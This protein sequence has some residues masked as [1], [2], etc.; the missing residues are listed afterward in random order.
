VARRI[1]SGLATL[2]LMLPLIPVV[3]EAAD[4]AHQ[5]ASDARTADL[6]IAVDQAWTDTGIS[7][8]QGDVLTVTADGEFVASC[9]DE[10]GQGTDVPCGP[11]GRFDVP[12]SLADQQYPLAAG[13]HG[14]APC[15]GLI[16]RIDTGPPFVVGRRMSRLA[17]Q[18][19]RLFLGINDFQHQHNSG[20][21]RA[22]I[23]AG[24]TLVPLRYERRLRRGTQAGPT[25]AGCR[26]VVFYIDGLRPDVVQEMVAM[27]HLPVM[28]RIF[29]DGGSWLSGAVTAFPSDTITSNGTM[30]TGCFSDRHGLKG[31]VRFSRSR[32]ESQSYLE[33]LGPSRSARLLDPPGI[34]GLLV[35]GE[36]TARRWLQGQQ[37]SEQWFRSQVTATPP[38]Y[39]FLRSA[40]QDWSTGLLPLMTELPPLL[41]TR[42]MTRELPW[43]GAHN[44]WQYVDDANANYTVRH[45]LH[46]KNPVTIIWFPETDSVSHKKCRGQFGATRST[47]ADAD[48]LMGNVI[49]EIDAAGELERTYF[50]LVSDHG[51]HGG[52]VEHLKHFDLANDFAFRP[53]EVTAAG[54]W[55][56][57]GLGLSVRMHRHWNRHP[58][59]HQREFLFV[60]GQSD[61]TAR[62]F[63]PRREIWSRDWSSPN[64]PGDLLQYRISRTHGP[65]DLV[66]TISQVTD[67]ESGQPVVDLVLV[68]LNHSS[69]LIATADRGYAV[70]DR[71]LDPEGRWVY[72]YRPATDVWSDGSGGVLYRTDTTVSRDPLELRTLVEP[73]ILEHY[74]DERTWLRATAQ[75]RYP[76]S[77]VALTRHMLWQKNLTE[78]ELEYAPDLVVTARSGWYFGTKSTKGT[79]HGYP[80]A[81]SMRASWFVSGPN[82]RRQTRIEAPC[83]LVDLTPTILQLAGVDFDS[84]WFD[85]EAVTAFL[86]GDQPGDGSAAPD[87]QAVYWHDLDLNGWESLQYRPQPKSLYSPGSINRPDQRFDINNTAYNLVAVAD[88]SIFRLLDDALTPR[89]ARPGMIAS[90][91]ARTEARLRQSERSWV[92]QGTQVLNA[93]EI[94]LMDYSVTSLGN[95]QRISGTVDWVQQRTD[96]VAGHVGEPGKSVPVTAIDLGV[97][98]VQSGFWE[99]Y[100]FGQRL[101]VQTLDEVVL[102]GT[103]N[104]FDQ[105]LNS[106]RQAPAEVVVPVRP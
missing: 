96:T 52:R 61:G 93:S 29:I 45:L 70:I 53:R 76:D 105:S 81:D 33:P 20:D 69:I 86:D 79:T 55:V 64:Q 87:L 5:A 7:L 89:Q 13:S 75:T 37:S 48:R 17:P 21:L 4:V 58:E 14:P 43:M 10:H 54:E 1:V 98:R 51:H 78:R 95:L 25:V 91:L 67:S 88:A 60:D 39:H 12:R 59:H 22:H 101:I 3:A 92:V 49:D 65:V 104:I 38:I 106:I 99:L 41:W 28:R 71:K 66:R 62:L 18:S 74:Y 90:G 6:V 50:L 46:R 103:E 8:S 24:G 57:G 97:D 11:E 36:K 84:N 82:V 56:G 9:R 94:T 73:Q 102:N 2:S 83:R 35:S 72:R 31:Q 19:G 34:D 63:L 100:R 47:I 32:L 68:R 42:S 27:G 26:V 16:G 30:W 23:E 85:G 80:L 15:F 44:A 77:V 40:G